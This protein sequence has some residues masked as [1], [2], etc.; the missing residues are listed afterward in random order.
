MPLW[1]SVNMLETLLGKEKDDLK[2]DVE[3]ALTHLTMLV[4]QSRLTLCDPTDCSSRGSSV[5]GILQART[6]EWVATSF[7][8]G[9]NPGIQPRDRTWVFCIAGRFFTIWDT[10]A[11]DLGEAS[12]GWMYSFI[13]AGRIKG[14]PRWTDSTVSEVVLSEQRLWVSFLFVAMF[15]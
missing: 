7:S 15:F 6:L 10:S 1:D 12:L 11:Y 5:H 2:N 9:S 8:R 14:G 13:D 4:T 3:S